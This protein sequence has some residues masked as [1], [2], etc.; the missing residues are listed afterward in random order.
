MR[1]VLSMVPRRPGTTRNESGYIAVTTGLMLIV[2]MG[3][4]AFSVDLGR[5]YFVA[6]QEQKAADAGAL[7]GVVALPG[8]PTSAHANAR[9]YTTANGFTL[10]LARRPSPAPSPAVRPGCA[11][12]SAAPSTTSS[13]RSSGC[14][15]P[16]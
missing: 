6:M 1:R 4:C 11:S 5:W 12:T 13:D 14:R 2:F 9:T 15:R 16:R 10:T 8:D 7:A 3:I